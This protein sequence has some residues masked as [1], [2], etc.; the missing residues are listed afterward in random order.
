[1]SWPMSLSDPTRRSKSSHLERDDFE[2]NAELAPRY[3]TPGGG[4]PL[5]GWPDPLPPILIRLRSCS[6][7]CRLILV[8]F[9]FLRRARLSDKLP[10]KWFKGAQYWVLPA[11]ESALRASRYHQG[12][13]R[14]SSGQNVLERNNLHL[15]HGIA[16]LY[17]GE[18]ALSAAYFDEGCR[19]R[20]VRQNVLQKDFWVF[21]PA[22][23][24]I[25]HFGRRSPR[26]Q[27]VK[28][29]PGHR[30]HPLACSS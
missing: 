13:R 12:R 5:G 23:L 4:P 15:P 17:F 1:M 10:G 28:Y 19:R 8:F 16:D 11:V 3:G 2:S 21:S 30:R 24:F 20:P 29:V 14:G 18:P 9:V 26:T 22:R 7:V 6:G 27:P 25:R